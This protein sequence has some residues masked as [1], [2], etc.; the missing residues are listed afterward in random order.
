MLAL[1]VLYVYQ[2]ISEENPPKQLLY[3]YHEHLCNF[4][5]QNCLSHTLSPNPDSSVCRGRNMS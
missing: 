1:S 3:G 2:T 4:T 5:C